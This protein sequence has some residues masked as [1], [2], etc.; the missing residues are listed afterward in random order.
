MLYPELFE[1]IES[2]RW[3]MKRD[4]PWD[5]FDA[6]RRSSGF[7]PGPMRSSVKGRPFSNST[8]LILLT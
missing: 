1:Q 8:S 6:D 7:W 5:S 2:V 3:N 4:I